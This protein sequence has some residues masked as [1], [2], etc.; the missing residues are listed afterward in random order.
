MLT[1]S[2]LER[3]SKPELVE[4]ILAL[5]SRYEQL[6]RRLEA[7]VAELER[8]L[9]QNPR[10]SHRPPS[11]EGYRKP[12]SPSR[13]EQREAGRTSG[14]QK[15]HPGSTLA[16]VVAD[17]EQIRKLWPQA[18]EG[19]GAELAGEG[20]VAVR[21]QVH[22]VP[23]L[24]LAVTEWQVMERRCSQCGRRCRGRLPEGI[25]PG[26]QYGPG[27]R[28]FM[29]YLPVMHMVPWE[30]TGQVLGDLLGATVSEGS[31]A[32]SLRSCAEKVESVV[33]GIRDALDKAPVAHFDETGLR[34]DGRLHWLHTAGTSE[35]TYYAV[36]RQRGRDAFAR[37]GI[38]PTFGG[39]ACHDAYES[40]LGYD[41]PHALCNAHL[42][43]ELTAV[44]EGVGQSWATD[45]L[46]VL[47]EAHHRRKRSGRLSPHAQRA[48]HRRYRRLIRDGRQA[49][50][51]VVGKTPVSRNG[52]IRR[53]PAQRL[54]LRLADHEDD[55]L[56]F[57]SDPAIPFDN[58]LAERDLRMMKVQQKV[59]GCFR[60]LPGAQSFCTIR[61]YLSTMQK[62][63]V[64]V[65][66][67]L[68]SV[69]QGAPL[70]PQLV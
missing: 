42:I 49:N 15:G 41:C 60:T 48:I 28:A 69:F 64:E 56:L 6:E 18:C 5:Q 47:R 57:L 35:L 44:S 4:I 45:L 22:D 68:K 1:R 70:T 51:F 58:N 29:V 14:G 65:L 27:L 10:N 33:A 13:Q 17:D 3:L 23:P 2:E 25:V 43:R 53:T 19:C 21:A 46:A 50:P 9:G 36:D 7:R 59:S 67:A 62:Q 26:A 40:Y 61:S 37:I 52:R 38:L 66:D 11:S 16:M 54:L 30:R 31:I 24:K 34:V 63:G 12:P 8:Q 39:V 20:E 55:Y 32:T